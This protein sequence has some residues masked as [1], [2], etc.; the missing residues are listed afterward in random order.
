MAAKK[1]AKMP[2]KPHRSVQSLA[3]RRLLC[4]LSALHK[5]SFSV[6]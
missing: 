3:R 1:A 6:V 5:M 2:N 4:S